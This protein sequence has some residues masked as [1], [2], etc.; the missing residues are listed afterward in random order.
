M[1]GGVGIVLGPVVNALGSGL[2]G[3]EVVV[4]DPEGPL[5]SRLHPDSVLWTNVP[6]TRL[7]H[8]EDLLKDYAEST[9]S[10]RAHDLLAR[11]AENVADFAW[12]RS[13]LADGHTVGDAATEAEEW[14]EIASPEQALEA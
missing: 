2:T 1:K 11:W 14:P 13:A 3:G 6:A 7:D 4:H 10:P 5:A 9:R 12:V 8:L